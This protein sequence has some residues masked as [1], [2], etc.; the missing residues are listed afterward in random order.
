MEPAWRPAAT[1]SS[2]IQKRGAERLFQY[3]EADG[4]DPE[5][6]QKQ[7]QMTALSR[8]ARNTVAQ[9]FHNAGGGVKTSTKQ[10]MGAA[11]TKQ[12]TEPA[13]IAS[14]LFA[15]KGY[16]QKFIKD[17]EEFIVQRL[18]TGSSSLDPQQQPPPMDSKDKSS[19]INTPPPA[20]RRRCSSHDK[21]NYR[22]GKTVS[23][24]LPIK[25]ASDWSATDRGQMNAQMREI[26]Q[27]I[28]THYG[29]QM[30]QDT[31]TEKK[32]KKTDSLE[33]LERILKNNHEL[34][35]SIKDNEAG[36][37]VPAGCIKYNNGDSGLDDEEEEDEEV[38]DIA[39]TNPE[40][41]DCFK[42]KRK[43]FVPRKIG[44][45]SRNNLIWN[46]IRDKHLSRLMSHKKSCRSCIARD[47]NALNIPYHSVTS[48]VL[49]KK[50]RHWQKKSECEI[51]GHQFTLSYQLLLHRRS[52]HN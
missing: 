43:Q 9:D 51:C 14:S 17:L 16:Q 23:Q 5:D 21:E 22:H 44:T 10:D 7:L 11:K 20:K 13:E 26:F 41:F 50:W 31:E 35:I 52:K 18:I 38:A 39:V 2:S 25:M 19:S 48:L 45:E 4:S 34:T 24:R 33:H 3:M 29:E 36:G 42:S 1:S 27:M 8:S 46:N 30:V 40:K 28:T 12:S 6:Y 47:Q 15:N 37:S 49:H 32:K